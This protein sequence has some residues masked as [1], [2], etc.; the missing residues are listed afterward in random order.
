MLPVFNELR[1]RNVFR[2]AGVYAVVGWLLAQIAVTLETSLNLPGWFDSVIV[3]ALII[4][5]PIA[6]LFAWAFEITPD[7]VIRAESTDTEKSITGPSGRKMDLAILVGLAGVIG[8]VSWQILTPNKGSLPDA[9]MAASKKAEVANIQASYIA[10]NLA[11]KTLEATY[12]DKTELETIAV[13]PFEDYSPKKDQEYFANGISEELL[14]VLM[15][16]R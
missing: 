7:G 8:L 14:N 12:S 10:E 5:L 2:V 3:S 11:S 13:L 4:G 15:T 16:D 6:I 1:R 9:S